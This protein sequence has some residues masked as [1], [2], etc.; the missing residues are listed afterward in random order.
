MTKKVLKFDDPSNYRRAEERIR[1]L[2]QEGLVRWTHHV[3]ERMKRRKLTAV[4]IEHAIR[5]GQIIEH[6]KPEQLWRYTLSGK[7]VSEPTQRKRDLRVVVEID[8]RLIII[9]VF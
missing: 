4:H 7:W 5:Y 2:F 6:S 8:G 1:K 9:T 3:Q